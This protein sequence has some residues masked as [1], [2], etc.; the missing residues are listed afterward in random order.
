[1]ETL[2]RVIG[3]HGGMLKTI[4]LDNGPKLISKE[5]DPWAWIIGSTLLLR[6]G[7]RTDNAFIESSNGSFQAE[8]Q[9]VS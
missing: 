7:E 9:D 8:H 5:L 2:E 3:M 6:P 1:M 4:R